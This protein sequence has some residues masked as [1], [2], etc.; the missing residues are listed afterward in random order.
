MLSNS[1]KKME[2]DII[3]MTNLNEFVSLNIRL[4]VIKII[5]AYP[6]IIIT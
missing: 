4:S 1:I 6:T 3:L 5:Q 2:N